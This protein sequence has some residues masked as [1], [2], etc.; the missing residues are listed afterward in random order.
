MVITILSVDRVP[1][2]VRIIINETGTFYFPIVNTAIHIMSGSFVT[3]SSAELKLT[4]NKEEMRIEQFDFGKLVTT[5]LKCFDL[6]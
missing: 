2:H 6:E 1:N 3:L 4:I 5:L